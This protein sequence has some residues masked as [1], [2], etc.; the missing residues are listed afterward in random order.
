MCS[1]GGDYLDQIESSAEAYIDA[2]STPGTPLDLQGILLLSRLYHFHV[3]MAHVEGVWITSQNNDITKALFILVDLFREDHFTET[4]RIGQSDHYFDSLVTKMMQGVMPSH[5]LEIKMSLLEDDTQDAHDADE[6]KVQIK[7]EFKPFVG[8]SKP[9]NVNM[10]MTYST[11]AKIVAKAMVERLL[12]ESYQEKK[13][14]ISKLIQSGNLRPVAISNKARHP[15]VVLCKSNKKIWMDCAI[16]GT[17]CSSWRKFIVHM[18]QYHPDATF[19]CKFCQKVYQTW[20]GCYKHEQKH[21]EAKSICTICGQ[22]FNLPTE[23]NAHM[24]VHDDKSKFY[25]EDCGKGYSS[26]GGLN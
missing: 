6:P 22:A 12:A 8:F 24:R 11:A 10:S 9:K 1:V 13:V 16:C 25:C 23:L 7:Y 5:V 21:T 15:M 14:L 20:N 17:E 4:C 3:A 18:Q 2:I 26:K 19:S